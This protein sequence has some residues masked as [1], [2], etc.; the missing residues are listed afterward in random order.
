MSFYQSQYNIENCFFLWYL[1]QNY[2]SKW[3]DSKKNLIYREKWEKISLYHFKLER[4]A[5]FCMIFLVLT[6]SFTLSVNRINHWNDHWTTN[7]LSTA[8]FLW[9]FPKRPERKIIFRQKNFG[10]FLSL[11]VSKFQWKCRSAMGWV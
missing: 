2:D 7:R 9:N 3:K 4:T 5:R 8:K 10:H 1:Q 11:N 6:A